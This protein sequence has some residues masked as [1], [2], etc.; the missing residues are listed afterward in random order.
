MSW[1]GHWLPVPWRSNR[2]NLLLFVRA[3]GGSAER[4][5]MAEKAM[6]KSDDL[7]VASKVV[8]F[9]HADASELPERVR[10]ELGDSLP[11]VLLLDGQGRELERVN[12]A[13][14]PGALSRKVNKLYRAHW[15]G[16]LSAMAK[17]A[18]TFSIEIDALNKQA[19]L[20][21]AEFSESEA[22]LKEKQTNGNR[23]AVDKARA[24]QKKA[25]DALQ[26]KL[27]ERDE[28]SHPPLARGLLKAI[29]SAT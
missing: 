24:A 12:G 23:R 9:L 1:E 27:D 4:H 5:A 18:R 22:E 10:A 25:E 14:Q 7:A 28:L 19:A 16:T 2:R 11:A 6:F 20:A 21:K 29:A 26:T 17:R 3:E 8:R 13:I 15:D